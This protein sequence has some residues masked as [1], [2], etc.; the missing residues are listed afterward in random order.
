MIKYIKDLKSEMQTLKAT[1]KELS[2]GVSKKEESKFSDRNHQTNMSRALS[3]KKS[4][5]SSIGS[6]PFN[7]L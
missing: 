6:D 1:V 4:I 7:I 3:L 5:R 2:E